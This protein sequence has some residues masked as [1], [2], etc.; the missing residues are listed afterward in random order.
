MK[1]CLL[2]LSCE[3]SKLLL[4]V[5][6]QIDFEEVTIGSVQVSAP[7]PPV[8]KYHPQTNFLHFFRGVGVNGVARMLQLFQLAKIERG[9]CAR[10]FHIFLTCLGEAG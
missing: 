3:K 9:F 4:A 1:A 6:N 7:H 2:L 8:Q 5:M 10:M